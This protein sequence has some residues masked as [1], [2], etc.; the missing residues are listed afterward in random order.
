MFK[1]VEIMLYVKDPILCAK[2]W[3]E[4]VGFKIKSESEG[5]DKTKSYVITPSETS[6]FSFC[7]LD[8]EAVARYSPEVA[9]ATPSLLFT[10]DDVVAM[11]DHLASQGVQVGE[12]MTMG[13]VE[14]CNF[15]D[16]EGHYFA[17]KKA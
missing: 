13:E 5:P 9:L 4:K 6:S 3:S 1:Q 10:C 11:R 7:L 8:Q 2:F 16:P 17:F 15:A 14:T 12:V